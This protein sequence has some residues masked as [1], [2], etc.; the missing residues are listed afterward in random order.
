MKTLFLANPVRRRTRK[1]R[2]R[3]RSKHHSA[4]MRRKISLAVKR[5]NRLRVKGGG[6]VVRRS[7]RS[8]RR[9]TT[10]RAARPVRIRR[11]RVRRRGG[12]LRMRVGRGLGLRNVLSK[13]N[14]KIAAG[15]VGGTMLTNWVSR[16]GF[17]AQ[18]PGTGNIWGNIAYRF[19]IP[20][21]LSG[22]VRRT[23]HKVADGMVIGALITGLNNVILAS[24]MGSS[25]GLISTTRGLLGNGQPVGEYFDGAGYDAVNAFGADPYGSANAFS[26]SAW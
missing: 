22:L 25:G 13:D 3:S 16:Q 8:V 9:I 17:F 21:L 6:P 1:V 19:L 12:I 15:G 23:D 18:L 24:T 7:R 5:A 10:I 20:V 4:A 14:L 2:L 11:R 26:R